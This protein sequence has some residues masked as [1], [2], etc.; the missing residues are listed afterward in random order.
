MN[1]GMF[2]LDP[3][4]LGRRY[5]LS[6]SGDALFRRETK[7]YDGFTTTVQFSRPLYRLSQPIGFSTWLSWTQ[8]RGQEP[9]AYDD[10]ETSDVESIPRL[11]RYD[12]ASTGLN[13]TWQRGRKFILRYTLGAGASWVQRETVEESGLEQYPSETRER[14]IRMFSLMSVNGSIP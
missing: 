14:F 3:N 9:T 8:G 2:Y 4:L 10:P 12:I 1:T 7:A 13:W 5:L 6:V 11:W